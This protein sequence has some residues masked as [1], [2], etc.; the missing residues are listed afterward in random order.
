MYAP[1][2][3]FPFRARRATRR[4]HLAF[5]RSEARS[6][7]PK[8]VERARTPAKRKSDSSRWRVGGPYMRRSTGG[9]VFALVTMRA[10]RPFKSFFH[11]SPWSAKLK[12]NRGI[13][14]RSKRPFSI[15]G[16]VL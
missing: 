13:H 6:E 11:V 1:Y 7:G 14:A 5:L 2:G 9:Q 10:L 15:A 3:H 4:N 8:T 16:I 12:A